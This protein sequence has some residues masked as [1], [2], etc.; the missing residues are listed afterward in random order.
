M[1]SFLGMAGVKKRPFKITPYPLVCLARDIYGF[2]N[3]PPPQYKI[4]GKNIISDYGLI[5]QKSYFNSDVI[6][7]YPRGGHGLYGVLYSVPRVPEGD[8]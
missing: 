5:K 8:R 6:D 2:Y 1:R 3:G 4:G 7:I